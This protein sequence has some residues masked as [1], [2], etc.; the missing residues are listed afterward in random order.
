LL[1][2]LEPDGRFWGFSTPWHEDDLNSH[3]KR[4][5]VFAHFRRSVGPDLEPVWPEKWPTESLALR[6]A[7]IGDAEFSRAFRL[8]SISEGEVLI[9]PRWIQFWSGDAERSAFDQLVLSVDPAVSA[10][11]R[12]DASALVVLGRI[13]NEIRV[14]A[15]VARRVT[16]PD[17][18]E[19]IDVLEREWQPDV[20]VFETNAAFEGIKDLLLRHARFGSRIVGLKQSKSKPSRIGA[21]SVAV[22]NGTVKLKGEGG[23]VAPGQQELFDE[24]TSFPLG[25]HDDLLDALATGTAHLLGRREQRLWG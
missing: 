25:A 13:G 4:N 12:A 24:M 23:R 10:K 20:I 17:L 15:A 9:P 5:G 8:V 6:R 22:Q 1:N 19:C 16:A 18:V 7:E 11:A 2:L 3:L 21:F 14:L